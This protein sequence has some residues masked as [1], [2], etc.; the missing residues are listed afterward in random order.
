MER[1]NYPSSS[2]SSDEVIPTRILIFKFL[3][4]FASM[5]VVFFLPNLW[6]IGLRLSS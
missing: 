5:P 2:G 1:R 4:S 6:K 3:F